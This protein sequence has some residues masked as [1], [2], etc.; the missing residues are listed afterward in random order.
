MTLRRFIGYRPQV[1]LIV[2]GLDKALTQW[3]QRTGSS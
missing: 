3:D 1:E 2:T